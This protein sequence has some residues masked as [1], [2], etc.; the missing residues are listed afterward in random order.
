MA[1]AAYKT[2]KIDEEQIDRGRR[3]KRLK[4]SDDFAPLRDEWDQRMEQFY[5]DLLT[6][7]QYN[8]LGATLLMERLLISFQALKDLREWIDEEIEAGGAELM[9]KNSLDGVRVDLPESR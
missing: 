8:T 3:L 6:F 4:E 5:T 2:H 9:R 7:K 1:E